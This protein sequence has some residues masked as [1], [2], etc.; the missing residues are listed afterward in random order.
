MA[1]HVPLGFQMGAVHCGLKRNPNRADLTLIVCDRP[2]T[3]AGVYTQNLVCAAPVVVDRERTP[4]ANIRA[5]VTN[6]GCANACTGERGEVDARQ[7]AAWAAEACGAQA[8][9]ALVMSTGI[10]GEHLKMDKVQ[11]GIQAVSK[12]LAS[13]DEAFIAAAKGIMTTDLVHKV[14]GRELSLGERNVRV[15]GMSKGSGM[16]G[17][18]MATMLGV[19]L[20]DAPLEPVAAQAILSDVA[21]RTFNC[22]SVD[23]HTSTNDTMILL[24]SG[25]V[26]GEPLAGAELAELHR[27]VYEVCED[28]AKAIADDGEGATHLV[29]IDV[30][31]CATVAD[32]RKIAGTIANSPLVKTAIAGADP[33]WGRIVSAA[34]YAQVPFRPT[35]V[36]LHV[37]GYLLYNEAAPVPFNASEVSSSIQDNRET[38]IELKLSEGAASAR[39][40]TCDF[41]KKY[42]EINADYHT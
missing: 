19:V 22:I 18:N 27:A 3:A 42:I 40:W 8:E 31:G 9:E 13:D 25:A 37:N 28:L 24:A 26:G 16:I 29:T 17:P 33:N 23:G 21:D 7:M 20:T 34:G 30:V 10:I 6:S 2:A 41:T 1:I 14:S 39:F 36:S 32:A 5:V 38:K 4:S 15:S 11:A 12:V 35:G